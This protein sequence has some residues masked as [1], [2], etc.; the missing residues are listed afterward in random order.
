MSSCNFTTQILDTDCIG[1]SRVTINNNFATLDTTVCNQQALLA[2]LTATVAGFN[3]GPTFISPILV[4]NIPRN[5]Q[6]ATVSTINVSSYVPANTKTVILQLSGTLSNPDNGIPDVYLVRK[7][8]SSSWLV[9]AAL[10]CS[11]GGDWIAYDN[12]GMFPISP[13]GT[14]DLMHTYYFS[15]TNSGVTISLIGYF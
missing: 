5:T 13:A 9:L 11:G 14:F 10:M 7:N 12:Q 3:V 1:D 2:S 8:S 6:S 15:G 4:A